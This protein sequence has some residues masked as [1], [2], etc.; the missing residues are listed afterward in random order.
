MF[1][2][3]PIPE[4]TIRYRQAPIGYEPIISGGVLS[5]CESTKKVLRNTMLNEN[6]EWEINRNAIE[7][8]FWFWP[9]EAEKKEL[10]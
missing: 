4:K 5:E 1:R 10:Q 8:L 2:S 7:V 6:G 9:Q 3:Y